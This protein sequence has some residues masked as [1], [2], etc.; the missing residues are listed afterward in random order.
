MWAGGPIETNKIYS[1]PWYQVAQIKKSALYNGIH[2]P[3][4]WCWSIRRGVYFMI[5]VIAIIIAIVYA[6]TITVIM[7]VIL[8]LWLGQNAF[9]DTSNRHLN[10]DVDDFYFWSFWLNFCITH[11]VSKW[12]ADL[13]LH[14]PRYHGWW[15]IYFSDMN[16]YISKLNSRSSFARHESLKLVLLEAFNGQ[17]IGQYIVYCLPRFDLYISIL[18]NLEQAQWL[19]AKIH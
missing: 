15:S 11:V 12:R 6:I 16:I 14:S 7:S 8:M 1:L 18:L 5:F 4:A 9:Y 10:G 17:Q 19:L 13:T 2:L 3:R